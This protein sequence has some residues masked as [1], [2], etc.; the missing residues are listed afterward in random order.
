MAKAETGIH[1]VRQPT[2]SKSHPRP[3]KAQLEAARRNRQANRSGVVK[4][5]HELFANIV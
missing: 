4:N 3:A 2:H 1:Q 5:P